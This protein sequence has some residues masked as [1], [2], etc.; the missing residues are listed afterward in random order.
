VGLAA[1]QLHTPRHASGRLSEGRL[2]GQLAVKGQHPFRSGGTCGG[3][4]GR[5]G[6]A[7]AACARSSPRCPI[8]AGRLGTRSRSAVCFARRLPRRPSVQAGPPSLTC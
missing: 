4:G 5:G 6:G 2:P 7:G 1:G 3:P 8:A